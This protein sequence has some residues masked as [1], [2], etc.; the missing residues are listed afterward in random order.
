M[1]SNENDDSDETHLTSLGKE[2]Q[3]EEAK[4]NERSP[5]VTLLC[6]GLLKRDTVFELER[7][8]RVCDSFSC[9]MSTTVQNLIFHGF[10][11]Q[12]NFHKPSV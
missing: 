5:N 7:E 3:T 4:E 1:S 8:L 2:F 11:N 9:S 6:A 10:H 12:G